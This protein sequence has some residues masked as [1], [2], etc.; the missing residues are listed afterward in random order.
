MANFAVIAD[1]LTG[2]NATG[3]LLA[4][5]GFKVVTLINY[6]NLEI[7][8]FETYDGVIVN[9]SSRSIDKTEALNRVRT[10]ASF[11]YKKGIRYFGKRIDSTIRGNLGAEIEGILTGLESEYIAAVVPAYPRSGRIVVGDYLLVNGLPVDRTEAA[12]DPKNPVK[13]SDVLEVIKEQTAMPACHISL[14]T[15]L[16]GPEAIAENIRHAV[17]SGKK[18]IIFDA[19][20]DDDIADI[21]LGL[22]RSRVKAVTVDPGPFTQNYFS[23]V[24]QNGDRHIEGKV[25]VIS[26]STTP[27]T[28]SQLGYLQKEYK[29]EFLNIDGNLLLDEKAREDYLLYT[30]DKIYDIGVKNNIF[31]LRVAEKEEML[32]D[33]NAEAQRR[34]T[35]ADFLSIRINSALAQIAKKVLEKG[36]PNLKGVYITGGDM[37]VAF[38]QE[39]GALAVEVSGD[40][41]PLAAY[42]TL[43][44]GD[45]DGLK[46][47]T[48]GGLV[49]N[50]E[51]AAKC[52]EFLLK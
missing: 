41:L 16:K 30:A 38:C 15:I 47:V 23:L 19:V 10:C 34:N 27:L 1:D 51:S 25:M 52:V 43:V 50:T 9:T 49:G 3:A 39:V 46:I 8:N 20:S 48:K 11:M 32:I 17:D 37:T 4:G 40:V 36:I 45:F 7:F 12:R 13:V 29:A 5:S 2:S 21:A 22:H 33:L 42:G 26:A 18:I 14:G 6:E 24:I 28:R 44:G 35:T 31:G